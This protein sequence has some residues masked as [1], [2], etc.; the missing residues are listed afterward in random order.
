VTADEPG[1]TFLTNH[2][3]VLVAL[4]QD[5]ELRLRDLSEQVGITER[6]VQSILSDLEDAGYLKRTRVGRR[7]HYELDLK[8]PL[9]HPLERHQLI[10][11]LVRAVTGH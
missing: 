2:G 6:A 10:G 11:E 4:A 7:N 8:R 5:P 1:W 3:H 9:R